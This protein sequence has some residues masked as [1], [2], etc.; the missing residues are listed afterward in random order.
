MAHPVTIR[1]IVS[2]A[3]A[4]GWY[5]RQADVKTAY[6]NA[7]LPEPVY[8]AP[9]KG[10]ENPKNPRQVMRLRKAVYGLAASGRL[11]GK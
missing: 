1:T 9:P 7:E 6:L 4:N 8:L 10:L 11:W 5:L 2:V 3:V